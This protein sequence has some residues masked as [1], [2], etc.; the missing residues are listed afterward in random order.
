MQ[1]RQF[2]PTKIVRNSSSI[3]SS[4]PALDVKQTDAT[5]KIEESPNEKQKEDKIDVEQQEQVEEAENN[6]TGKE[7]IG[8]HKM[9]GRKIYSGQN[10]QQLHIQ[11][12]MGKS[13]RK[14]F[15]FHRVFR[16]L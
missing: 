9:F 4:M 15:Q 14:Y 13:G 11:Y 12:K 2:W 6:L 7:P 8:S 3:A 5:A 10:G 16:H 1:T